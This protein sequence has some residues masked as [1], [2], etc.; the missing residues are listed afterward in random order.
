MRKKLFTLYILLIFSASH[1]DARELN[2]FW[3]LTRDHILDGILD[4]TKKNDEI[5]LVM[6]LKF[7]HNKITGEYTDINNDSIF[8]GEIYTSRETTLPN[9]TSHFTLFIT[10]TWSIIT[11]MWGP[12]LPRATCLEISN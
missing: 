8:P 5:K 11:I 2:D 7:H 6:Q 4:P 1:S 9:M 3:L 10:D 12:G